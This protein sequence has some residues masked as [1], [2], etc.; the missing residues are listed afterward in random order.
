[1]SSR[2][3]RMDVVDRWMLETIERRFNYTM[4]H[5][6][7]IGLPVRQAYLKCSSA[8]EGRTKIVEMRGE[9]S[10]GGSNRELD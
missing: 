1:M 9:R 10:E 2:V 4:Q 6:R 5:G 3:G 8:I 7:V